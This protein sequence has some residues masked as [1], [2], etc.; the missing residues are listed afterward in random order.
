M[1][2]E[3][4]GWFGRQEHDFAFTLGLWLGICLIKFPSDHIRIACVLWGVY[5]L[6]H[7]LEKWTYGKH[8]YR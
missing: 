3:L 7:R 2:R 8:G 4:A 5:Y 1:R 6:S